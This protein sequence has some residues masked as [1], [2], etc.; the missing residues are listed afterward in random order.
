MG[1]LTVMEDDSSAPS[2][3]VQNIAVVV[4]EHIVLQDLPDIPT[5][6]AFLFGL[7]Y[8]LNL[9]YPKELRYTF[10]T[11]QKVFMGLGTDLSARVRTLQ[12]KLLQ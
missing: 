1:I 8:A 3:R 9:E 7:I 5:A 11:I 6:V 4:E 2:A 12:N 10:E